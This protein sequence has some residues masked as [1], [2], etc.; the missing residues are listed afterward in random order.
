[1]QLRREKRQFSGAEDRSDSVPHM[2]IWKLLTI[3]PNSSK[4][5]IF[6]TTASNRG[7]FRPVASFDT[8]EM[9]EDRTEKVAPGEIFPQKV[10]RALLS[11]LQESQVDIDHLQGESQSLGRNILSRSCRQR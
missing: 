7:L 9:V 2:L 5:T 3:N 4:V 8:Y 10:V 6:M 1:M 11:F